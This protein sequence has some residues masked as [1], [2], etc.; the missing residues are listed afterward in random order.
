MT[1]KIIGAIRLCDFSPSFALAVAV[2]ENEPGYW[3]QVIS[4]ESEKIL[5]FTALGHDDSTGVV[6]LTERPISIGDDYVHAFIER[7]G[8]VHIGTTKE[9]NLQ[10]RAA[11]NSSKTSTPVKL[12]LSEHLGD[13]TRAK[14]LRQNLFEEVAETFGNLAGESFVNSAARCQLWS[15]LEREAVDRDAL[16]RIRRMRSHLTAKVLQ[17]GTVQIDLHAIQPADIRIDFV[18]V[19]ASM[20]AEFRDGGPPSTPVADLT[21]LPSSDAPTV[22]TILAALDRSPRQEERLAI[23]LRS[24]ILYPD[25]TRQAV[26]RYEDPAQMA[27]NAIHHLRSTMD[28]LSGDEQ[29]RQG[30]IAKLVPKLVSD[31]YPRRR[32]MILYYLAVHLGDFRSISAQIHHWVSKSVA[33]DVVGMSEQ[34][35][36]A[37]EEREPS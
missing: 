19:E 33:F 20:Q 11:L 26:E 15:I 28:Y 32:G 29:S 22:I 7:M 12:T 36:G 18:E 25:V 8:G 23:L 2:C 34:I 16:E 4:P 9:L 37:L 3:L 31:A 24:L 21:G 17:D 30:W 10:F 1:Y 13:R 5:E 35:L 27:R 14:E 6:R